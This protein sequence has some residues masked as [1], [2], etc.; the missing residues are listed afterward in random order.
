MKQLNEALTGPITWAFAFFALAYNTLNG[1]ISNFFYQ[2]TVSFGYTPKQPLLYGTPSGA[3]KGLVVT[4][5][6]W[7]GGRLGQRI[8]VSM[9]GMG[10]TIL[11]M[12]LIMG[13]PLES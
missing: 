9:S 10:L 1:G 2:L 11:G 8:L 7:L 5:C 3:V 13:L 6:G 4:L 12:L